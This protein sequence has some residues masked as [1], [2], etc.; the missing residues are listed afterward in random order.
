MHR[1]IE[2]NSICI[3]ALLFLQEVGEQR[4]LRSVVCHSEVQVGRGHMM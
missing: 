1:S 2:N 4:E 3:D